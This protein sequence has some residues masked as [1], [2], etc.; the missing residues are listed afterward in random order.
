VYSLGELIIVREQLT[1]AVG[2][3]HPDMPSLISKYGADKFASTLAEHDIFIDACGSARNSRDCQYSRYGIERTFTL[4]IEGMGE[5]F[6]R[7]ARAHG[8]TFCPSS[9]VHQDNEG[10][11]MRD[12]RNAINTLHRY[13]FAKHIIKQKRPLN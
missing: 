2:L 8:V 11:S 6:K 7:A 12:T 4:N 13:S 1:C 5:D 9:D 10:D 3:A